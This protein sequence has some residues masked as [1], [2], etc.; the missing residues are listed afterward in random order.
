MPR[1]NAGFFLTMT[2]GEFVAKLDG[3]RVPVEHHAKLITYVGEVALERRKTWSEMAGMV[4]G[5]IVEGLLREAVRTAERY[6]GRVADI[7]CVRCKGTGV[8]VVNGERYK[9]PCWGESRAS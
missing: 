8:L 3:L 5:M 7:D 4:L 2:P 1:R 9:C 6:Q